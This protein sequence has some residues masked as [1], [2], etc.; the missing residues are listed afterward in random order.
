MF[1]EQRLAILRRIL[2]G[3]EIVRGADITQRHADIAKKSAPF[4]PQDGR[5]AEEVFELLLVEREEFTQGL[6]QQ[7]GT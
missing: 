2:Q 3:G 7:V 4:G 5:V 1:T 6:G